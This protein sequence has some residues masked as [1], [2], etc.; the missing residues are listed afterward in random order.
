MRTQ[1]RVVIVGAGIAGLSA[2]YDLA[3]AGHRVTVLEADSQCGGL[4]N[5]FLLERQTVDRYYHF[6]CTRDDHLIQFAKELGLAR[7]LH[8]RRTRTAYFFAGKMFPFGTPWH[9]LRFSPIPFWQRVRFGLHVLLSRYRAD[10]KWLDHIPA[11]PWL[12]ESIGAEAY[13]AI[14]H[15]LL[16]VK[17]GQRADDISAAWMWHRIWRV[18]KSRRHLLAPEVF[19]SFE[20]GN[21]TLVDRLVSVL[22]DEPWVTLRVNCPAR[23]FQV[24][25]GRVAGVALADEVV[26]CDAAISTVALPILS[27]LLQADAGEYAAQLRRVEYIGVVCLVLS[28]KRPFSRNFWLNVNDPRIAFNGIVEPTNLNARLREAGLKV[29]YIPHYLPADEPLYG[30]DEDRLVREHLPM[31]RL[32]NP[33]FTPEWIRD[34]RVFRHPFAQPVFATRFCELMPAHRSPLE[35]LYVSDSSQFYPE[36]RTLSAAIKQGRA[37]AR[38]ICGEAEMQQARAYHIVEDPHPFGKENGER[39]ETLELGP[40]KSFA[41]GETPSRT[42]LQV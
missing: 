12:I 13:Q 32:I 19:G 27:R 18:A 2:A 33:S 40:K 26:P 8:W 17:F 7:K 9:L 3:K 10:W 39:P 31:L 16:S 41:V 21:A 22:Q 11:K 6:V 25:E 5:S 15:P 4:A 23:G 24:R 37:I 28:L 42:N 14:W 34:V 29:I 35:G 38:M 20:Q 30:Y 1:K 36:D